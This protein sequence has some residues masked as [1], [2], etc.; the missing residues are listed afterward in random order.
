MDMPESHPQ[1]HQAAHPSGGHESDQINVRMLLFALIGLIVFGGFV[2]LMMS[3][4]FSGFTES[5][6]QIQAQRPPRFNDNQGLFPAPQNQPDPAGE[7]QSLRAQEQ[8]RLTSYGWVDRRARLAHIPIDRAM[9]LVAE[10]G[11]PT[12]KTEKEA[13]AKRP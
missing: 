6:K 11:L 12:R 8:A 1:G 3:L 9:K 7:M 4:L 2:F 10:R 13:A 5:E